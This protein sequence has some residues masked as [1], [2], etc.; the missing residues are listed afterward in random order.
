VFGSDLSC[1]GGAPGGPG[2]L[3]A[4]TALVAHGQR[5]VDTPRPEGGYPLAWHVK[6]ML[7]GDLPA[8]AVAVARGT[9]PG[10]GPAAVSDR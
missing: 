10:T 6:A 3:R 5:L 2:S 8:L 7:V 4:T 9:R 1:G